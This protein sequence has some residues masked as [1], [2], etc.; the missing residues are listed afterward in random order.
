[1]GDAGRIALPARRIHSFPKIIQQR[2][3]A[4]CDT[5]HAAGI[6]NWDGPR[7]GSCISNVIDNP[8]EGSMGSADSASDTHLK[9]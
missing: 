2:G 9:R 3:A 6:F 8:T 5:G 4:A 7:H 1:M